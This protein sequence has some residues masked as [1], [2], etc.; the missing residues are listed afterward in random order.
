MIESL[1]EPRETE[2]G[3]I[4]QAPSDAPVY[5]LVTTRLGPD[6]APAHDRA[7]HYRERWETDIGPGCT[8]AN[9]GSSPTNQAEASQR[10][11]DEILDERLP[12]RG[13]RTNPR[14]INRSMS[15]WPVQRPRH[16][17]TTAPPQQ[18]VVSTPRQGC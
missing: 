7:N 12:M 15:N 9:T 2:E 16:H 13:D 8:P 4:E 6:Q 3:T 18:A 1:L 14:A 10:A 17:R 5:R 11:L